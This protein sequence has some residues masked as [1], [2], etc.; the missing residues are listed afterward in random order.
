MSDYREASEMNIDT[1]H[2]GDMSENIHHPPRSATE[3]NALNAFI[4]RQRSEW[5]NDKLQDENLCLIA[6]HDLTSEL[7][8]DIPFHIRLSVEGALAKA[9]FVRDS[10]FRAMGRLGGKA[11][12][13]DALQIVILE[14]VRE[15]PNIGRRELF[16]L[17]RK[18]A[19]EGHA[20]V[21][22][23]DQKGDLLIDQNERIYFMENGKKSSS[24]VLGLKDRLYRAK[25]K[26]KSR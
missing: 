6:N 10:L 18:L 25:K 4:W 15:R 11:E 14:A 9:E 17:M 8:R 22:Q 12:K 3:L 13:P 16:H 26:I 19:K 1:M 24:P 21:L 5:L 20:V 7:S 23:V 2:D